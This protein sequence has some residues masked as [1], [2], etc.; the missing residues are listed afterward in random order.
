M[1]KGDIVLIT[2]P[3]TD[4]SGSKL[5]PSIV[6]ADTELDVTVCFITTQLQ[7]QEPTDIQLLSTP[8]NGLRKPSL[9]RTSKIA[10]LDKT[11]AKGLLGQLTPGELK[12]LD[13]KLKILFQLS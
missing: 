13:S 7:W 8:F 2:F 4:L 3:F 9:I 12:G 5:R 1:V 6:L 11:L 10:T